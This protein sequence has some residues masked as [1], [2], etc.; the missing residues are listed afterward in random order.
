M[1]GRTMSIFMFIFMGLA[2]LSSAAF[3]WVMHHAP[4]AAV[5]TGAG[6][7]IIC[8]AALAWVFTPMRTLADAPVPGEG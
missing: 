6:L 4:L 5:F 3:G 8:V 1:L 2:P 7:L